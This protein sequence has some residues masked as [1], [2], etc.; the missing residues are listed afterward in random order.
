MA[1]HVHKQIGAGKFI[2]QAL[3]ER[4]R[5]A[6]IIPSPV[7]DKNLAGHVRAPPSPSRT[8]IQSFFNKKRSA[9]LIP[10]QFFLHGLR[11]YAGEGR[12][13]T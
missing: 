4:L 2:F 1:F 11:R 6:R 12:E 9:L 3:V 8:S 5:E 13:N 7:I 10:A